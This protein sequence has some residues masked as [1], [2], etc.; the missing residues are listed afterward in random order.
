M[1]V[2]PCRIGPARALW[3]MLE[4]VATALNDLKVEMRN[5]REEMRRG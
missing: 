3:M 5:L 1:S 2:N 4:T